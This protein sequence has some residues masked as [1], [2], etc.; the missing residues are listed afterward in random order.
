MNG[1]LESKHVEKELRCV[2][3]DV[4]ECVHKVW[5]CVCVKPPK[6]RMCPPVFRTSHRPPPPTRP[7]RRR[8]PPPTL[9]NKRS[10]QRSPPTLWNIRS[11]RRSPSMLNTRLPRRPCRRRR[12]ADRRARACR[13]SCRVRRSAPTISGSV[14]RAAIGSPLDRREQCPRRR[15]RHRLCASACCRAS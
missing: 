1:G 2:T 14:R 3:S 7:S 10:R 12:A 8:S 5:S 11:R 15:L 4:S 6:F 13:A 9:S